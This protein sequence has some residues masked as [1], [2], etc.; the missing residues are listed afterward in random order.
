MVLD[1]ENIDNPE[2]QRKIVDETRIIKRIFNCHFNEI[3][4][5]LA[6]FPPILSDVG[7]TSILFLDRESNGRDQIL[8][9]HP[10]EEH[11]LGM[12]VIFRFDVDKNVDLD[13]ELRN[14]F[15]TQLETHKERLFRRMLSDEFCD[16]KGD[17]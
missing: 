12:N 17:S 9:N 7:V 13:E 16:W 5:I 14:S 4:S 1:T 10:I 3:Q 15:E 2:I 6:D 11:E 8:Y